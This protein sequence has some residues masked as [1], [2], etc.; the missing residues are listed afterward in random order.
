MAKVKGPK[1]TLIVKWCLEHLA[2]R[3]IIAWRQNTGG[4]YGQSGRYIRFGR[5]GCGDITGLLRNGIRLEVEVKTCIGVQSKEQE[6]FQRL[7]E[8]SNGIYLLVR[9][10]Q[11]LLNQLNGLGIA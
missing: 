4:M 5:V 11:D 1:E 2:L 3:G 6:D 10:P 9:S 7:I 8:S